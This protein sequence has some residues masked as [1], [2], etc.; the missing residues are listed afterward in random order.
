MQTSSL[1]ELLAGL[2]QE[3]WKLKHNELSPV[4]FTGIIT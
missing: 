3:E 4:N 1:N 2:V